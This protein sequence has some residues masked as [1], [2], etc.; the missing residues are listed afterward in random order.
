MFR[1]VRLVAIALAAVLARADAVA[2]VPLPGR[3]GEKSFP[4]DD[5]ITSALEERIEGKAGLE[6]VQVDVFW[7]RGGKAT[8]ARIFGDGV[9][10]WQREAQFQL[11]KAR[12]LDIL[13]GIQGARLGSMPDQFGEGEEGR[14]NEGPRL[15]GRLVVRA[16]AARKSTLQLVD[17]EQSERFSRLVEKILEICRGPARKGI[18][19]ASMT[20]ALRLLASGTLSP[21]VLEVAFQRRPDPKDRGGSEQNW[22][23]RLE[24]LHAT[25]EQFDPGKPPATA[26]TLALSAGE[27]HELVTLLSETEPSTLPQS[28]YA[29]S[30]TDFTI[31]IFR[32]SRTITGRRFLGMTAE[33]H[34][35]KQEAFDRITAAL[36]TLHAR[37]AEEG[38][39]F[40][41]RP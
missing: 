3:P 1:N 11:S 15:K 35:E 6:D 23:L 32:Y 22:T 31:E 21:E 2:A 9:G 38:R 4:A 5:R 7:S 36:L 29:A 14:K 33:T 24:G 25:E 26:R 20:D 18:G 19:A 17:G 30:Y 41:P 37:V 40:P 16:G 13:R 34:G 28:L 8:T 10:I 12:V 27:F 39:S